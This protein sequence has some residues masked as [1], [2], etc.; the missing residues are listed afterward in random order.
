MTI[1]AKCGSQTG[2]FEYNLPVYLNTLDCPTASKDPRSI[3]STYTGQPWT[4]RQ[5]PY[6][7]FGKVGIN[8]AGFCSNT[9]QPPGIFQSWDLTGSDLFE[10]TDWLAPL[11]K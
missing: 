3:P 6:V 2:S 11:A 1:E 7:F 8:Q 9:L 10:F 4:N 5:P